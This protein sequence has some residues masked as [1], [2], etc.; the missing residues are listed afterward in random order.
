M[1]RV[2]VRNAANDGWI[3]ASQGGD[4]GQRGLTWE[5]AWDSG[6]AYD[7]DDAVENDG[8]AYICTAAHTNQEPPN[9]SYWDVLAEKG[10][11]GIQGDKGLNWQGVW[12]SLTTYAVDDAVENDGVS[13]VCTAGHTNQEPPN[14]S[15]W[16]V[17]ATGAVNVE[18][19]DEADMLTYADVRD[20]VTDL[21]TGRTFT[22]Q[23]YTAHPNSEMSVTTPGTGRLYIHYHWSGYNSATR[24]IGWYATIYL[25]GVALSARARVGGTASHYVPGALMTVTNILAADT[26]TIDLRF[27]VQN[28]GD[29][30]TVYDLRGECWFVR[31]DAP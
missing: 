25:D 1:P 5:G 12:S 24:T 9:A 21:G 14:A 19:A 3:E 17:L 4:P 29:T 10:D 28:A 20:S 13:Y 26:Y 2:W 8:T 23:A 15:Y 16:D 31:E 27:Y 11:Q 22:A 7:V 18:H 6:T 30:T